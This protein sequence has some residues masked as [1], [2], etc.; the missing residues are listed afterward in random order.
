VVLQ[1]VSLRKSTSSHPSFRPIHADLS[2]RSERA[3]RI[4]HL[5]TSSLYLPCSSS[6]PSGSMRITQ[7]NSSFLRMY[8]S[9]SRVVSSCDGTPAMY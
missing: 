4:R 6:C 5:G 7:C 3:R 2:Y 8:G 9:S 1:E